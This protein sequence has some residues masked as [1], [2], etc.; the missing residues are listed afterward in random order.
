MNP[1]ILLALGLVLIFFEFFLPGAVLGIAGSL[2][3]IASLLIFSYEASSAWVFALY[4]IFV[5]VLIYLL[6]K[7]ALWRI[8]S[9]K[10]DNSF[11][12]G[13]DQEGY[14]ADVFNTAVVGKRG[15]ATT[16][17]R[18]AGRILVDGTTYQAISQ[19]DFIP[20]DTQI[21]VTGGEGP[22]LIVKIYHSKDTSYEI[23]S[24]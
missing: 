20:K 9:T 1:F 13:T 5:L 7:F 2:F 10:K 17:L 12:L 24:S 23:P 18:P 4:F 3:V 22:T 21:I 8:R 15:T 6:F 19:G 14:K 11:Y 16:D